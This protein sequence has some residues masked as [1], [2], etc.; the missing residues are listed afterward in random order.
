MKVIGFQASHVAFNRSLTPLDST[1]AE[2]SETSRNIIVKHSTRPIVFLT[3]CLVFSSV[4]AAQGL[5]SKQLE[6]GDR[7]IDF[8]LPIVG[9]E[10]YLTLSEE[11]KQG[12]VVVIVL[13]GYPGYQCPI[14]SR[15]F[16][17]L[18]NRAKALAKE[19]HRVILVYPG[20][21]ETIEKNAEQFLGSRRLPE[22]LV[23]V[24]DQGMEMV[25]QWGLRWNARKETAYP[26]TYVFDR[27]ARLRW[28]KVSKSKAG[29]STVEEI[30]KA[31]REL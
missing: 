3:A 18:S 30:L 2:H 17:S 1:A 5:K 7:I 23:L 13:R 19:A 27:N 24:R 28:K 4:C 21:A 12:A 8:E 29:R 20:E 9:S 6:I 11:C 26:A 16:G 22:P 31:L 15:Q 25:D 14:C 10:E